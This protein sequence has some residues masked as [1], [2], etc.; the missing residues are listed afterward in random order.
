MHDRA[1][2]SNVDGRAEH[3][4][5]WEQNILRTA[6][7]LARSRLSIT[8]DEKRK[9]LRAVYGLAGFKQ[10]SRDNVAKSTKK[11]HGPY[12]P[13]GDFGLRLGPKILLSVHKTVETGQTQK[14]A[15]GQR[16]N[17]YFNR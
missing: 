1:R 15:A 5:D 11:R 17:W 10:A 6:V 14:I 9:G 13:N 16:V 12:Y 4:E 3:E 2:V 8:V 7:P